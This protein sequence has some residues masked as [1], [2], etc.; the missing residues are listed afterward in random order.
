METNQPYLSTNGA[1][2]PSWLETAKTY[3]KYGFS[4]VT[5]DNQKRP[6]FKW[7]DY[8]IQKATIEEIEKWVHY[9]NFAGLAVV[10]GSISNVLVLD[11]DNGADTQ[12]LDLPETPTVKTPHGGLHYYFKYP[13]DK[14]IRNFTGFRPKFD[15]RAAAGLAILPPTTL[16]DGGTYKWIKDLT[17]PLAETPDW[18]LKELEDKPISGQLTTE[19]LNG[20]PQSKRNTS[21]TQVIGKFLKH[22]KV[23]D[24]ESVAWPALKGWNLQNQP[25]LEEKEL[26]QVFESIVSR[27]ISQR[28]QKEEILGFEIKFENIDKINLKKEGF[29]YAI[30]SSKGHKLDIAIYGDGQLL[31]R[32]NLLVTSSKSRIT[33][34]KQC[35]IEDKEL[36]KLAAKH[37]VEIIEVLD[38]LNRK[39]IKQGKNNQPAT[40]NEVET[41]EAIKLLNSP[42]LFYDILQ[43]VKKLGV[44][45]E[46]K[47]ALTHYIVF[48]SRIT[49]EPLSEMVKGE[50]AAGK[51]YVVGRIML[52][53]PKDNYRDLTDATAQSFFY[54]PKDY[55]AHK[56]ILIFEKHGSEK[57]DYSIRSL[58][59][60]KKLKLQVTIKDPETGQ[61]VTNEK[62][63]DGPV[64]FVTTTTEA[65]VHAEN[66][67]RVLSIYPD[68][69][70]QQT[71]R[72]LEISDLKY[73]GL[74]GPTE[75]EI[76][77]WQNIQRV[78]KP[79]PVF[80]P[81]VEEIRKIFPKEP[82]RVRRDYSKFLSLLSVVA[83]L[84]QQQRNKTKIG[85]K[86]YLVASLA[87]FYITK[88]LFEETL[89]KTIYELSPKSEFL[90]NQAKQLT[91]GALDNFSISELARQIGWE[92]D[93]T[94]KWFKPAY[95]KGFFIQTDEQKGSKG[96]RYKPAN[97]EIFETKILPEAEELYELNK[98]WLG[99]AEIYHPLTGQILSFKD[100]NCT[101]VLVD[102]GGT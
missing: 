40:L 84:H 73:R 36:S 46:E 15:I 82:V 86:E 69:S 97:K 98:D 9:D 39:Q 75:A 67:T 28:N 87:D 96:A 8:Q 80:I 71:E 31:N 1:N 99:K 66:E 16:L 59:S 29:E 12:G 60:E 35:Q 83:L 45:G 65:Q 4:L 85:E 55:F 90:I 49:D 53:F 7:K 33:F 94:W 63:V 89:Q 2:Y 10:T 43:F 24:W 72:I 68:E 76:K 5:V 64:G 101:D 61:F 30:F 48:T 34:I 102:S 77:K 44:I 3:L 38:E 20:V 88:I 91:S 58:Q 70:K 11:I 62:E 37:L 22:F 6:L 13:K 26:R 52:M 19:V 18:L 81:F 100:L 78:L 23:E 21:A 74:T 42:I 57:T 56:I 50:S 95:H 47:T 51:S 54:V 93:T 41:Q 17:T 25:P 14:T 79:Y 32:D 92:Y 27:E